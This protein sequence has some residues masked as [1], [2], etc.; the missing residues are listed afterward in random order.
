ME[1]FR[2]NAKHSLKKL[3]TQSTLFGGGFF[4]V[5]QLFAVM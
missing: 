5:F 2:E 4:F 3:G 1:K